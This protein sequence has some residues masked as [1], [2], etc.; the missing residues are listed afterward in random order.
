LAVPAHAKLAEPFCLVE[1]NHVNIHRG[2]K[3]DKGA[4]L[5]KMSQSSAEQFDSN[6]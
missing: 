4:C 2:L 1:G 6:Q 3:E 5:L